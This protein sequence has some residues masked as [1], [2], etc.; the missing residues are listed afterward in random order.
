MAF[1]F[2][3]HVQA[4]RITFPK[5]ELWIPVV[6]G[7]QNAGAR[8]AIN[9]A[10]RQQVRE[11]AA[12]QGSLDDP[13]AEMQGYFELKTN[14]KSILSLSLF[15]Y[16]YT[17]GAHG[18]TLQ[19]SLTFHI[20]TGKRYSLAELFKPGSSYVKRLSERIK[21]Q[22]TERQIATLGE[23]V[24]IAPNQSFYV[25]D[26]ALVIYFDLYELA[27]YAFGFPYFPISV[28][29]LADIVNP[30]GPLAPMIVND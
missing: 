19:K 2:P 18:L 1:Q 11:L 28:F 30:N 23:F 24:S 5:V 12:D 17:G 4:S 3:V 27:P 6:S 20:G 16:A 7:V 13:R 8:N 14:E 10:I 9:A 22:I 21:A 26:R 25:A 29:E 15:N